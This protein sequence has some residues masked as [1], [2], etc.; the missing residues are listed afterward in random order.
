MADNVPITAGTG[1]DIATDD[2]SG[3]HF[4][5]VKLDLG[6]DGASSPVTGS[7][8]VNDNNGSLTVDIVQGGNTAAVTAASALQVHIT[9]QTSSVAVNGSL[10]GDVAHDA[11]DSGNPV[12]IGGKAVSGAP[13]N[14]A[15]GDRVDAWF[16]S[17]GAQAVVLTSGPF[18]VAT[19]GGLSDAEDGTLALATGSL[20][21]NGTTWDRLRGNTAGLFAQGNVAHDAVDAGNP[22]KIGGKASSAAPTAV[23][24]ADRV[25]AWFSLNGAQMTSP[26]AGEG[27][28]ADAVSAGLWSARGGGTQASPMPAANYL[29][30][31][32]SF[33]RMRGDVTNGLDVDVTRLPMPHSVG[34]TALGINFTATSAQTS[35][36]LIA[37][38]GGQRIYVTHLT[39]ATGGTTAGRVSIY[40][41]TGAFSAGTSQTVFDGEFAPSATARPGAVLQFPVPVGG[42][43]A[44]GDNLR[45][46]TSAAMT[47]YVT[48]Q[49][50]KA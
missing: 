49:A 39:I 27:N 23:A 28:G 48:G 36:N 9:D 4:Q 47:I 2:V 33:D 43:S 37:G 17:R 6:D 35:V 42:A 41:G 46:T 10:D 31:G 24:N 11:V 20:V 8:P 30:N 29:Y 14:V 34:I 12:K 21:F 13:D 22:V 3:V 44:T 19:I 7:V 26:V 45:I 5:K 38:T 40:Y 32:A 15:A 1:T 25:E 18:D 50:Y 16:N